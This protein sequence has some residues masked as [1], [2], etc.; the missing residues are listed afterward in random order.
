MQP[1]GGRGT[2][3]RD[4]Q[5]SARFL[6]GKIRQ[7]RG[8]V[9]VVPAL[10]LL[11]AAF[12]LQVVL[13]RLVQ[14]QREQIGTLKAFGYPPGRLGR[15]TISRSR[16][17]RSRPARSS[18]WSAV[19]PRKRAGAS[20]TCSFFRLPLAPT[21]VDWAA[22]GGALAVVTFAAAGGALSAVRQVMRLQPVE[23]M[24]PPAPRPIM[25]ARAIARPPRRFFAAS[26]PLD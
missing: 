18:A 5:M 12:V 16:C 20:S 21:S 19:A 14:S 3:G 1:Y 10:F 2:Y 24:R 7:I 15:G 9:V 22:I 6:D 11:V 13:G 8:M 26:L 4:Q 25:R 23:A 17:W